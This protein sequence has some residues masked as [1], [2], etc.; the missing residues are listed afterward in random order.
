MSICSANSP[1]LPETKSKERD[2]LVLM[3]QKGKG[4]EKIN[5]PHVLLGSSA[6]QKKLERVCIFNSEINDG[7]IITSAFINASSGN[8]A[9]KR[10]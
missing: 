5:E 1:G 3:Q 7:G 2:A 10:S 4:K 9:E 6:R 8:L